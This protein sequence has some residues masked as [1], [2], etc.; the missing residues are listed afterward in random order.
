[1]ARPVDRHRSSYELL[2]CVR[3][4]VAVDGGP[5]LIRQ[6]IDDATKAPPDSSRIS[7]EGSRADHAEHGDSRQRGDRETYVGASAMNDIEC[8][9]RIVGAPGVCADERSTR[10][11]PS[12]KQTGRTKFLRCKLRLIGLA[13][14]STEASSDSAR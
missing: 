6:R 4:V 11:L 10:P 7:T 12:S 8:G 5:P 9:E 3:S 1:V 2:R 14:T 13:C